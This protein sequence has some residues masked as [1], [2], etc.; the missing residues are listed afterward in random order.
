MWC[1]VTNFHLFHTFEVAFASWVPA[2]TLQHINATFSTICPCLRETNMYS[3]WTHLLKCVPSLGALHRGCVHCAAF[4]RA[5]LTIQMTRSSPLLTTARPKLSPNM[6]RKRPET[7][8]WHRNHSINQ[9][10]QSQ[11]EYESIFGACCMISGSKIAEM[12]KKH[13]FS[14]FRQIFDSYATCLLSC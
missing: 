4:R 9:L 13:E 14:K 5:C 8:R 2:L 1:S 11:N 10:E 12:L 7:F 6:T 3:S